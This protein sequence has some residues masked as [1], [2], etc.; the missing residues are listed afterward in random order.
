MPWYENFSGQRL[1][2]EEQ[3][4]GTP[5]LLVHGWCMTSAIWRLQLDSLPA[6]FRVIA[7]D[8]RGFGKSSA[9]ADGCGFDGFVSDLVALVEQL[10]LSGLV[11]AGW[12]MGAEIAVMLARAV[13]ESVSG[14]VLI[15]GTPSFSRRDDF[16]HGL[17][18]GEVEGMALKV[19]RN[20]RRALAGFNNR[21]FAPGELDDPM[22]AQQVRD[23]LSTLPTPDAMVALQS[24]QS[25]AETD[26]RPFF[27]DLELPALIMN[28][29]HDP[30]CLP[31]ASQWMADRI[32]SSCHTVFAGAGHAPF[33]SR[34]DAFNAC[35]TNFVTRICS[36][37]EGK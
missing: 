25:L 18:R 12:S 23:L 14:L 29:E 35:L 6:H 36:Q 4:S 17:G 1:W 21:M 27:A 2:Y 28:G 20:I 3:G 10:N 9:V 32:P 16:P 24:L 19:R 37:L 8:L 11:L 26:I 15:S 34:P 13:K 33:L 7:P 30:I 31:D 22:V 5:L